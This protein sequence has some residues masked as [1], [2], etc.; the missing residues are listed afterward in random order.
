MSLHVQYMHIIL[1]HIFD[2]KPFFDNSVYFLFLYINSR[3]IKKKFKKK[4]QNENIFL[5]FLRRVL[6]VGRRCT[7]RRTIFRYLR[8]QGKQDS[9][10]PFAFQIL[11][12]FLKICLDHFGEN[13]IV[14]PIF[15]LKQLKN[16][17]F[18]RLS[19]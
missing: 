10:R 5:C 1:N 16:I 9:K 6:C 12:P 11:H 18:P 3:E 15:T 17:H 13:L 7:T 14:R 8:A 4:H 19:R 2:C